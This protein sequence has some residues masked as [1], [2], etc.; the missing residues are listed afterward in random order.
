MEKNAKGLLPKVEIVIVGVFALSFLVWIIPK[1]GSDRPVG[2][3][4]QEALQQVDSTLETAPPNAT[5]T[6][7]RDTVATQPVATTPARPATTPA[8]PELQYSRLYVTIDGLNLRSEPGLKS[9]VLAKIPLFEEVY[10][11]NE[12]TDSTTELSIGYEKANEPWVKVRTK[13]GQE[14]W[15]YGAGVSY[16]KKKRPGTIE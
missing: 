12:V 5:V 7:P 15:V 4:D 16:Y 11:L 9:K 6:P 8:K 14:G 2:E 10:F 3:E 1:C 13:K